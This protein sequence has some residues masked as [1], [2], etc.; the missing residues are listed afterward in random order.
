MG[1]IILTSTLAATKKL[2]PSVYLRSKMGIA[3][4]ALQMISGILSIVQVSFLLT[5][6]LSCL[7][8]HPTDNSQTK[9]KEEYSGLM[10]MVLI[11]EM[12]I[13]VSY[14]H[15]T[16]HLMVIEIVNHM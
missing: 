6:T 10:A 5:F 2:P 3:L 8:F 14:V 9:E 13:L 11:L 7:T 1:G 4:V 12:K 16:N 15:V